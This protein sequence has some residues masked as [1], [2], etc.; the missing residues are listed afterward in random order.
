[1]SETRKMQMEDASCLALDEIDKVLEKHFPEAEW[2]VE[3][4]SVLGEDNWENPLWSLTIFVETRESKENN[5]E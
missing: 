2:N 5:D 3:W 4:R 1:M